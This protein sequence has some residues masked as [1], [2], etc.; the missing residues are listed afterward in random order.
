M[1]G[2]SKR[3]TYED[4]LLLPEDGLRHEIIDGKHYVNASPVTRYQLVLYLL[5]IAINKYLE[6]HP[7]VQLYFAPLHIAPSQD[8]VVEPET[9]WREIMTVN[10]DQ[11]APTLLIEVLPKPN[12]SRDDIQKDAFY[13]RTGAG[14]YWI[15]DPVRDAVRVFRRNLAGRYERAAEL[16]GDDTLTSPLFPTL[17]IR[18]ERIFAD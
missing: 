10:N 6:E 8:E 17:E 18:L 4:L 2:T 1:P 5:I 3:W 16:S 12:K 15:V 9:T 13:E 14:E 7:L 11:A